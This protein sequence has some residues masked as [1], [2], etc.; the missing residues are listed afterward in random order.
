M[1]RFI[2][3]ILLFISVVIVCLRGSVMVNSGYKKI[4][5][6]LDSA[7]QFMAKG[8]FE[9]AKRCAEKAEKIY[10][11]KEQFL[12]AFVSHGV[13]DEVGVQLAAVAPFAEKESREEFMSHA[14]QARVALTHLHNDHRFML[15]NLF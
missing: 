5:S 7:E 8:D 3:S 9:S 10:R 2:I 12:A 6:E 15:G 13:L 14:A 11:E 4:C 1:K